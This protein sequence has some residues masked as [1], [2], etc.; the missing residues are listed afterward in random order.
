MDDKYNAMMENFKSLSTFE[1]QRKSHLDRLFILAVGGVSALLPLG[2]KASSPELV[3]LGI[4]AILFPVALRSLHTA[5]QHYQVNT[6]CR[7]FFNRKTWGLEALETVRKDTEIPVMVKRVG[8]HSLAAVFS[9]LTILMLIQ[10]CHLASKSGSKIVLFEGLAGIALM[11]FPI[12]GLVRI[13]LR[14][15]TDKFKEIIDRAEQSDG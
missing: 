10:S 12:A 7:H 14:G 13:N 11:A 15:Y 8:P 5:E 4:L 6:I 2:E 9:F 1:L 3:P